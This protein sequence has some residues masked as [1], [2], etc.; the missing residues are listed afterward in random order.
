M[1]F[2]D[3]FAWPEE[4]RVELIMGEPVDLSAPSR[5]HQYTLMAL[6]GQ[7]YDYL[8]DKQCQVYPAPFAVVLDD[9]NVVEPDISV[10]CDKN[11]LDD[12]G[13]KGVPDFIIEILSP[14][15]KKYDR[16]TKL[17]LYENFGLKEYWI[18]DPEDR[19][20]NVYMLEGKHLELKEK[21]QCPGFVR[22]RTLKSLEIDLST[23]FEA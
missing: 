22:I 8:K 19:T 21:A 11:K 3:Y 5:A 16:L 17:K 4:E 2:R 9:I 13:C 18:V 7:I 12:M 6:S 1:T 15:N 14:S 23:I 10:V 20:I